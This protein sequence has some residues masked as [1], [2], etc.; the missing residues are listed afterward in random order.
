MSKGELKCDHCL[1][2]KTSAVLNQ[3]SALLFCLDCLLSGRVV[4]SGEYIKQERYMNP[5]LRFMR[6][7]DDGERSFHLKG[8]EESWDDFIKRTDEDRIKISQRKLMD[9]RNNFIRYGFLE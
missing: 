8:G 6:W 4:I 3:H 7:V 5:L 1:M 2:L 9:F